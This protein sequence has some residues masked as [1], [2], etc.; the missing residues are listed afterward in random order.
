MAVVK[1]E[2]PVLDHLLAFVL[3]HRQAASAGGWAPL[4]PLLELKS[5]GSNLVL[6][7]FITSA[8]ARILLQYCISRVLMTIVYA[9][10][11]LIRALQLHEAQNKHMGISFSCCN[12]ARLRGC[13]ILR[14]PS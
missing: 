8:K 4:F 5:S 6:K 1:D 9:V 14:D 10:N 11:C 2:S 13:L 12:S 3:D 7:V